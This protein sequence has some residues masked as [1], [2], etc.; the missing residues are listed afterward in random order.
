MI[1]KRKK[2]RAHTQKNIFFFLRGEKKA[3]HMKK[4]TYKFY[5]TCLFFQLHIYTYI[6]THEKV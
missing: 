1:K 3:N 4:K 5:L 2:I 6:L